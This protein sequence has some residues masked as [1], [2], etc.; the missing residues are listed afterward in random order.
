MLPHWSDDELTETAPMETTLPA[1]DGI[2]EPYV[3]V[4][5]HCRVTELGI[6]E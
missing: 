3:P 6:L 5:F 2:E 4:R 1:L